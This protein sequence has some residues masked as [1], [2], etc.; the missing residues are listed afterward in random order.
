MAMVI[1]PD[2]HD[3]GS[4]HSTQRCDIVPSRQAESTSGNTQEMAS[5]LWMSCRTWW[6][7]RERP[8]PVEYSTTPPVYVVPSSTGNVSGVVCS[9]WWTHWVCPLSSSHTVLQT[10]N[11][12]NWLNSFAQTTLTP[13]LPEPRQ[14]LRTQLLLTGSSTTRSWSSSRSSTSECLEQRTIYWLRFEWQHRRSPHVHGLAWLPDAPDVE[15]LSNCATEALKEDIVRHADQLVSTINP[16]VLPD[17]SNISNAPAPK[18]DPHI[19]NKPYG[20]VQDFNQ[21]LA[22]LVATCQRHTCCS[23]SYCL[24]TKHGKQECRFGYPKP[25]Q[26]QTAIVTEDEPTLLTARNDGMINSF[27]PVQL[28]ADTGK[29]YLIHCLQLLLQHQVVVAAP[30]GVAA[31][32]ID[33][34]T[35]HS[36][37]SLPTRGEFKD[38]EGERLTKLQQ[39]FSEVKYLIIDEMSMVGRKTFGQ[40]D[41]RLRQAFPHHSQEVFGGCS[42]LLF[43]DFG[44]LPPVMDLLYTTDSRSELCDQGR[45]AYQTFQQAVVYTG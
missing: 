16:A 1:L 30:T 6:G 26:P 9:P 22:D 27:N 41:R 36:L 34:H 39:A 2:T 25:L 4:S 21:D 17:G 7:D 23:A 14:S 40:V 10:S 35:L 33:G 12:Q 43:G 38:L 32:N 11:G 20:E 37:F 15:K 42:C 24:R 8:F 29:S 5:C 19:C 18:V 3:S 28:S 44:Q 45:A 31:F 13:G